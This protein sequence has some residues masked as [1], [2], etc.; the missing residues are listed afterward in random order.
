MSKRRG[1]QR[2]AAKE[3]FWRKVVGGFDA[4][5]TSVRVW[6]REQRVSEPSFYAWR[7]ELRRRDAKRVV[8]RRAAT[9]RDRVQLLRVRVAA[10]DNVSSPTATRRITVC[11]GGLRLHVAV[12]QLREVLDVLESRPC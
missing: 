7:R 12:E 2:D 9:K 1:P 3:Q 5:R 6:C 10:P 4:Q 11:R 8:S